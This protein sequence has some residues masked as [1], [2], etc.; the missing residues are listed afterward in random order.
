VREAE[1]EQM[2]ADEAKA[3]LVKKSEEADR[4]RMASREGL[5]R[6]A[7]EGVGRRCPVGGTRLQL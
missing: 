4:A 2:L 1:R 3:Q 5:A 6:A 7:G